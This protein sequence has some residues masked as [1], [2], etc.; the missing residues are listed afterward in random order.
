MNYKKDGDT[1]ELEI[2]NKINLCN[3]NIAL[4]E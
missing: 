2:N 3:I 1:G 4:A